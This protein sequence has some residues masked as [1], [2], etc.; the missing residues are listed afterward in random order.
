MKFKAG[1]GAVRE[2]VFFLLE[3]ITKGDLKV[4]YLTLKSEI[5]KVV[6][7]RACFLPTANVEELMNR[8]D[9][10]K[11]TVVRLSHLDQE[12]DKPSG[13]EQIKLQF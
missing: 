8:E 6:V 12:G 9:S 5:T 2:D 4:S 7:Y 3:R 1:M 10:I 13:K 11:L